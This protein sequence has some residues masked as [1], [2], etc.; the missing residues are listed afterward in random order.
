M[1]ERI[2]TPQWNVLVVDDEPILRRTLSYC[3]AAEG[4]TVTAVSAFSDAV[5]EARRR[6]LDAAF[7]D[8]RL[9]DDNGMDLIPSLLADSP[10]MKIVVITAGGRFRH[11]LLC[12]LNVISI[13]AGPC[14]K[15]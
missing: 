12:R 2:Q 5:D 13:E 6:S 1:D 9:G 10:R 4:H 3:L 8:L 11:D 14:E 7:V 15:A